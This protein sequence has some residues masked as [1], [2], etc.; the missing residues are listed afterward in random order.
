MERYCRNIVYK[1]FQGFD[2]ERRPSAS[3]DTLVDAVKY[4]EEHEGD[5]NVYTLVDV[6]NPTKTSDELLRYGKQLIAGE[7]LTPKG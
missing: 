2:W 7:H 5:K 3:F 6:E 4:I 1:H